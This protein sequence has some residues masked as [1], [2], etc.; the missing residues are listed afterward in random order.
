MARSITRED[1]LAFQ[2]RWRAVNE[3]QTQ[4]LRQMT[5]EQKMRQL[6]VLFQFADAM[7][8]RSTLAADD[9]HEHELWNELRKKMNARYATTHETAPGAAATKGEQP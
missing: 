4:E 8:W 1:A 7:G 6:D 3:R 5:V 2:A 9:W